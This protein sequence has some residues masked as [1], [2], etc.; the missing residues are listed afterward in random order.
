LSAAPPVGILL[1]A[2]SGSRFGGDKLLAT[3]PDGAAI[4]V[5]AY[6]RL[7]GAL[8][9]V[10]VVVRSEDRALQELFAREGATVIECADAALGMARSLIAGIDSAPQAAGWLIALADM[11]FVQV[12]TIAAVA[13]ALSEGALIALPIY[14]GRRGHPVGFSRRLRAQLLQLS[15]DEG[16]RAIVQRHA[17]QVQEVE[18]DDPG[19]VRDIDTRADLQQI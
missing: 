10:H 16:A 11:P 5:S 18:C 1:A 2:G 3:L 14:R 4:G 9:E 6:R 17:T 19:I 12:A 8:P 7:R 15:G 13:R